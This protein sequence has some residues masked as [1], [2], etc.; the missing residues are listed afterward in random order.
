LGLEKEL[1]ENSIFR[2]RKY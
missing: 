1:N 2:I